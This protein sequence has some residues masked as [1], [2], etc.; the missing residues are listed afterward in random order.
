VSATPPPRGRPLLL[1]IVK[2]AVTCSLVAWVLSRIQLRELGANLRASLGP[3][4]VAAVLVG[5]LNITMGA[6]RW[7]IMLSALGSPIAPGQ[8]VRLVWSGLFFNTFLPMGVVGDALR[9]AWTARFADRAHAYWS[10]VL[11]R[12]AAM[13]ALMLV[14]AVGLT[15]PEARALPAAP[16]LAATCLVLGVPALVVLA[17][18]ERFTRLLAR[19]GG[20]RVR[21]ALEGRITDA[22]PAGPRAKALLLAGVLHLLVVLDVALLARAAHLRLP[23]AILLAV[24]PAVLVASYLPVSI[25]GIGVREV[26]LVEL[27]GQA[28]VPA[29][30][31]LTVSLLILAVN[32]VLSLAG[33]G[34]YLLAG[35]AKKHVS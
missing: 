16:T 11:D 15:L 17:F 13:G 29:A 20:A 35:R 3:W 30:S 9:G 1:L 23:W 7:R 26:A 2:L 34:V 19:F 32:V 28:G 21:R 8:A 5:A 10:V 12:V 18:P 25:S 22:P 24:V 31:A 6:V 4:L 27:L 33:G 14:A